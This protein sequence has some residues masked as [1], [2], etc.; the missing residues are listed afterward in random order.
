MKIQG[1][2]IG[3]DDVMSAGNDNL[4]TPTIDMDRLLVR[5]GGLSKGTECPPAIGSGDANL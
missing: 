5:F 3:V 2:L 4:N 1:P